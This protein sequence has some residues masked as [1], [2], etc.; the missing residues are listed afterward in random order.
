MKK[1]LFAA[2]AVFAFGV[3]NAQEARFGAKAGFASLTAKVEFQGISATG[4]ESGFFVGGFADISLSDKFHFQPELLYV[5]VSDA[6]QVQIP[7]HAKYMI[8]E[9]IG[10]VV[11]PNLAFL[12]DSVQ[13]QKSFNYGVDLG[14]EYNFGD[15]FVVDARYNIG[16]AD[17]NDVSD[18]DIKYT[19]SG[20][21]IG[22]GY[23]F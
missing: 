12:T 19:L 7:L 1:L 6:N 17:L 11:G 14:A 23:K 4:S 3:S 15:N 10:I 20:F 8:N 5:A 9:G 2:V 16:L 13:G 22:L 18:S 21:Y